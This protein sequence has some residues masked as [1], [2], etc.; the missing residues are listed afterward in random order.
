VTASSARPSS[1]SEPPLALE[2]RDLHLWVC[3]A[4]AVADSLTLARAVLSRYAGAEPG[5]WRF[6]KG[7]HGKPALV[8][9]PRPLD[10]NLSDSGDWRVCAVTAG[11]AVG[12][13]LEHSDS[14]RDVMKLARRFYDPA[15]VA[16]LEACAPA[17]EQRSRFYDY[18]TLK[19]ARVKAQGLALGPALAS[20][21][22]ELDF[23]AGAP[24]EGGAGT[25]SEAVP[26]EPLGAHYCLLDL[27]PGYRLATCWLKPAGIL[28]RLRLFHWCPAAGARP[29][30]R[31]LRAASA[32]V[33]LPA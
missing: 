26:G 16:A 7:C 17:G 22:F 19:E 9:A 29:L 33:E 11:T 4:R 15:E 12:V 24:G 27:A 20:L 32:P 2:A 28:P 31:P 14:R 1:G 8:G 10:F 5:A 3:R 30:V 23:P 6:E 25:I 21:V 18:W 13:D